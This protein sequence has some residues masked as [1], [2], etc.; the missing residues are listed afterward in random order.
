MSRRATPLAL[1]AIVAAGLVLRI[2]Y[3]QQ[4]LLGDELFTLDHAGEGS[5]GAM[6]DSAD[7]VEYTPPLYFV[8]AWLVAKLGD[9]ETAIRVPAIVLGTATI[10]LVFVLAR[11]AA[12]GAGR[13][14]AAAG[15]DAAAGRGEAAGLVA[16]AAFALSPFALFYGSEARSYGAAAFFVA[17]AAVLLLGALEHGGRGR[18]VAFSAALAGIALSHY[19]A[20]AAAV[21]LGAWAAYARR[22]RIRPLAAACAAAAAAFLVWVPFAPTF[23]APDVVGAF[24]PLTPSNTASALARSLFGVNPPVALAD[25]PGVLP[26]AVLTALALAGAA[27]VAA[28]LWA[29]RAEAL[30]SPLGM[31]T[32]LALVTPAAL[33]AYSLVSTDVFV[34]R[35]LFP[36]APAVFAAIGAGL[37]TLPR[38]ALAACAAAGLLALGAGALAARGPDARRPQ[39]EE[40]A[41]FIERATRPGDPVLD[42]EVFPERAPRRALEIHLDRTVVETDVADPRPALARAERAAVAG[43][44]SVRGG[45]EF[46]LPVRAGMRQ[47][48]RRVFRGSVDLHVAIYAR[49]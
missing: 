41:A 48:E 29:G 14:G 20:I 8:L 34:A 49:P 22:D 32:G 40:A 43:F 44:P 5:F 28:R 25:A 33:L 39:Y 3:A 18:W 6:M 12:E 46:D 1:A 23:S 13:R 47:V 7:R 16:A 2:V 26:A 9:P 42:A 15:R 36:T 10:P 21:W 31:L 30:R 11:R 37:A 27:M 17:L 45:A 19:T 38:P 24:W 4:S 35:S